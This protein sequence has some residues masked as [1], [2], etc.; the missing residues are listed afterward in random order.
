MVT[1]IIPSFNSENTIAACLNALLNQDFTGLKEII[2]V[3]SSQDKTPEIVRN[4]FPEVKL[5]HLEQK[6]DP[7]TARNIGFK[8][9]KG[10]PVLFIDSDCEAEPDW[11]S[12][13][14]ALHQSTTYAAIGGAVL[15]G[16]EKHSAVAWAGYL[17]EFREFLPAYPRREVT[18]IPT[19][20]ISYKRKILQ[21][22]N[23][24]D[25]HFYP[26]EDLVFNHWLTK[27]GQKIL[28]DPQIRIRHHHRTDLKQFLKHQYR[29]GKITAKVLKEYPLSGHGLVRNRFILLLGV[30][31]LPLIKWVRTLFIFL[32]YS[33]DV[34][35]KH[36]LSVFIFTLGLFPWGF[37][38]LKEG[39]AIPQQNGT[40][41]HE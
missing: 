24:F 11:M 37:G 14:V 3:D 17:A 15:N 4:D 21:E 8:E 1:V 29:I 32:R 33:A 16:N 34:V 5:I 7:G 2:L 26:Q 12:R 10:D 28:F 19:C 41:N 27:N 22:S 20:N 6:T 39:M 23:G 9:S 35:I 18:H 13:M 38:F 25:P 30:W 36:P 40:S 31:F